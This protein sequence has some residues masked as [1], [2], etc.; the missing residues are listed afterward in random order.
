MF[1]FS[2]KDLLPYANSDDIEKY[3][4]S[5]D[6][7]RYY[8]GNFKLGVPILSPL[9][10]ERKPSFAIFAKGDK[11][12]FNDFRFGGG[13]I[14]QFVKLKFGLDF[15]G[16]INKIV[17]DA[18]LTD[19]FRSDLNYVPKPLI[20]HNKIIKHIKPVIKIKTRKWTD[21]DLQFWSTFHISKE[22]LAK[23]RIS[24][25]TYIFINSKIIKADRLAY[26]FKEFKDGEVSYT[27]YQPLSKTMKWFKSHDSSVFYGWS[28]LPETSEVLIMTKSMKDVMTIDSI[29]GLPAVA[30]QNE[31]LRPKA[32]V[33]EQ[34]KSRFD[35]IYLFYDNDY[36]NEEKGKDNYGRK[37]GCIIAKEFGLTQI[38]IPDIIAEMYDA[39]DPSDL[40]KYA[41]K[42]YVEM[43]LLGDIG[44][45][46]VKD[47]DCAPLIR[48]HD[49]E[50]DCEGESNI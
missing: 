20:R 18:G 32:H 30:L 11:V 33:I 19:K 46:E 21:N 10:D 34:L 41:G 8:V 1:N 6:M 23:Y 14:I 28:Q 42:E 16:A 44:N 26:V 43:M 3:V 35:K 49:E 39:K 2:D 9:E 15:R 48:S 31:K 13:D 25:I 37:F 50:Q 24:P 38:E 45:Y 40:A 47:I 4:N 17:Q 22:T 29:T 7:F 12:L 36:A 27:I 5:Y